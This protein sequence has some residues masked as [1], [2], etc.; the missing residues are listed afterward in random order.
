MYTYEM[1]RKNTGE[2]DGKLK[3][4]RNGKEDLRPLTHAAETGSR[5]WCHRPK[6]DASLFR[7]LFFLPMHDF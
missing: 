5:N 3:V 1:Y 4:G 7:H 6:F 2:G